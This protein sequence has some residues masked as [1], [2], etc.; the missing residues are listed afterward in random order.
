MRRRALQLGL[1]LAIAAMPAHA[2]T[3][4]CGGWNTLEFFEIATGS[5]VE[6]CLA[7]GYG[8]DARDEEYGF[9]PLHWAAISGN[10]AAIEALLGAGAQV[11][12]RAEDGV[13][14][15]HWAAQNG[16]AA[17]VEALLDAGAEVDARDGDGQTP[18]H[19]AAF[20]DSAA[21]VE[22]LMDAGAQ[23]LTP[24]CGGYQSTI[25]NS[26]WHKSPF[27]GEAVG[28]SRFQKNSSS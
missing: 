28:R 23:A 12:A 13:T 2:R 21:A 26:A 20:S 9:T 5:D 1:A 14:P 24:D 22:A 6:R 18:L 7:R 19:L 17:A 25:L 15:L 4:D 10:A 27:F 11:D 8:A 16:D 3:P